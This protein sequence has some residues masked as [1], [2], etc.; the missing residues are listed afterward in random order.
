MEHRKV[1]YTEG[2]G[3][4]EIPA[5]SEQ[6]GKPEP[7]LHPKHIP[8]GTTLETMRMNHQSSPSLIG[9]NWLVLP[10]LQ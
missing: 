5:L 1:V 10:T 8:M 7:I 4:T 6:R 3:V 2:E 9:M